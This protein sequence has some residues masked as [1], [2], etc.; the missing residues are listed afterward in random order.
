MISERF[1]SCVS[2]FVSCWLVVEF[3]K[4]D[5]QV[6]FFRSC[7]FLCVL[8]VFSVLFFSTMGSTFVI[9]DLF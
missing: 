6:F 7:I 2:V 1:S 3:G 4:V 9:I 8:F 5:I